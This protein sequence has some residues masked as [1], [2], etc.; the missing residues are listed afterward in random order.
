MPTSPIGDD[1]FLTHLPSKFN[2]MQSTITSYLKSQ[3][4]IDTQTVNHICVILLDHEV[5]L[6]NLHAA[7]SSALWTN[8]PSSSH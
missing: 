6:E 1:T 5:V 3:G 7:D 4:T 8:T 2:T